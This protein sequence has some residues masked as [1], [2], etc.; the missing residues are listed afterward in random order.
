MKILQLSDLDDQSEL[1]ADIVIIGGGPAGLT[2]AKEFFDTGVSVLILESGLIDETPDHTA[3]CE[4]ESVGDLRSEP[5]K[6]KRAEFHG[7]S[8]ASWTDESQPYGVRCRLLGGAT[9]AW[10]GKSAPFDRTDFAQ[11]PWVAHSG[12]P[13]TYDEL[14]PYIRRAEAVL[15]LSLVAPKPAIQTGT[16]NS[17][18]WQFARSRLDPLDVMRFG[19]EFRT[20]E[21]D[22][23]TV[24]LDATVKDIRLSEDG[25]RF[26]GLSVT[27]VCGR[28][29]TVKAPTAILAAGGI[30]NPRL[31]LASRGQ[32]AS[33]IGNA[34]DQVGRYL[35]DHPG[36]RVGRFRV[37]DIGP[38]NKRFGFQG[39]NYEGRMHMFMHGLAIDP[40][41]QE[42]EGLLNTAI[43][44]MPQRA[45]DDPWDALKR[46]LKRQSENAAQDI[47]S[48][49]SGGQ[50]VVAGVGMKALPK[51]PGAIRNLIVNAAIRF[52]PN[53][54]VEE[55]ETQGLPHK[56]TGVSIDAITENAPNPDSRVTL[57]STAVDRF[58]VPK[59]LVDWRLS[60]QDRHSLAR[61]AQLCA[62]L[63]PA[64][65]LP[66][67][68]LE[69]WITQGA[70]DTAVIIDMAHTAGTTRMSATPQTG[71]VDAQCQVHGVSGLYIA[72]SSVFPTSG[73]ANPTLMI[74]SLAIR[75]ADHLKAQKGLVQV[76]PSAAA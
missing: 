50:L 11:R 6:L 49:I 38:I 17:F 13:V 42:R 52:N 16:L 60:R 62:E 8:L 15:N 56:L 40:A 18:Y 64:L 47:K 59:A 41:V 61:V 1:S 55:F 28:A 21:A 5:Q 69:S 7:E 63:L 65:G 48:V 34:H 67:P 46:L 20:Y 2:I 24:L 37:E 43:Y 27:G 19:P 44:F 22:N 54:V 36:A 39:V 74:L 51:L 71:V 25:A 75:L 53:F 57:S 68:Q 45:P 14:Q 9:H 32:H 12:W 23:V 35:M 10:A 3:L 72:G 26:D 33:G 66:T 30:E 76:A 4:L 29:V 70:L 31:L 58:G 73:H